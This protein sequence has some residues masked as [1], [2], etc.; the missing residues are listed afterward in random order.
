MTDRSTQK[1]VILKN[2]MRLLQSAYIIP[3]NLDAEHFGKMYYINYFLMNLSNAGVL[4]GPV[5]HFIRNL[6]S[7]YKYNFS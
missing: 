7:K 4:V 1:I 5:L 2:T 3:K 6:M